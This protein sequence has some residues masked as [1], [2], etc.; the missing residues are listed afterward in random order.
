MPGGWPGSCASR[1]GIAAAFTPEICLH[2]SLGARAHR[3]PFDRLLAAT[4]ELPGLALVS[5]DPVF[6]TL[7]SVHCIW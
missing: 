2:A 6:A 4:A 1:G 5:K 3:D 7:G